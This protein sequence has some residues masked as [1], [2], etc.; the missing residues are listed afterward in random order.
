MKFKSTAVVVALSLGATL[1]FAQTQGV[2]KTEITLGSIQDVSGP[3]A[4]SSIRRS[5]DFWREI[6]AMRRGAVWGLAW[7][8]FK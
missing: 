2:T 1:S 6:G 5:N 3:L 4:G 8:M 7:G